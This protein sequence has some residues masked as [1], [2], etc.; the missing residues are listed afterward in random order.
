[1]K[2]STCDVCGLSVIYTTG[3]QLLKGWH[4]ARRFAWNVDTDL[5]HGT[6][7][8]R[9]ADKAMEIEYRAVM[10]AFGSHDPVVK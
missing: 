1:M 4:H 10:A 7:K 2:W 8:A 5:R 9:A 6:K 3:G